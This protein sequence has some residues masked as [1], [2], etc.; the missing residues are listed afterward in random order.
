MPYTSLEI[1]AA[2]DACIVAPKRARI[3]AKSLL[4]S[5]LMQDGHKYGNACKLRDGLIAERRRGLQ[6]LA[7]ANGIATIAEYI[8]ARGAPLP[9]DYDHSQSVVPSCQSVCISKLADEL[10][11]FTSSPV[12][13]ES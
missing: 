5:M 2:I 11:R 12:F 1:S 10:K 6:A 13:E 9:L 3:R 7:H 8:G 4:L